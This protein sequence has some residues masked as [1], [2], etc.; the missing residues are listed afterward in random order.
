MRVE[1]F[2]L[3]DFFIYLFLIVLSLSFLYPLLNQLAMS[4]SDARQLEWQ[5]IGVFPVGWSLHSY[6]MLLSDNRIMR[7]YGNTIMYAA[8]GTV[9]MLL[10]TSMLAYPLTFPD[11]RGK[12]LIVILLTITMFF[13]GGL[14]PY[15][16]VVL[17]LGL[18]DT[19]WALILPGAIAAWNVIIFRTFFQTIPDALKE[20]AHMDGAGHFTVLFRI[21][22]PLSKPLLATFTLFSVVGFWNDWFNALIFLRSQSKFPV[23]LFLRRLIVLMDYRDMQ[24]ASDIEL[25][26]NLNARTVKS[27]ALMITIVPILCVYP[28][29]Q[30]YFTKGLLVGSLKA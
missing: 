4:V 15:Y 16:L 7:Y 12:K 26:Q 18:V 3:F 25:F 21:I 30:R 27:A 6:R 13:S 2:T 20:S 5:T 29:L 24:S 10:M 19:I 17:A 23:Q 22:V 8:T 28:F 1:R 11:F 14:I 9:A